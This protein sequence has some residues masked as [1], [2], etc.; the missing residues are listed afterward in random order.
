MKI[1]VQLFGPLAEQAG[2]SRI[3]LTL[4]GSTVGDV[5]AAL[6][7][8]SPSLRIDRSVRFAVNTDYA[9]PAAPVREGDVVSLIPPVGGG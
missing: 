8:A 3:D 1:A 5:I 9:E 2:R 4:S 6:A 7:A